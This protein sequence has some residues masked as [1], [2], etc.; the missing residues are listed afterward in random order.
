[1]RWK[2]SFLAR[3]EGARNSQ[4]DRATNLE[5]T[6]AVLVEL[7]R[8]ASCYGTYAVLSE[9]DDDLADQWLTWLRWVEEMFL[10]VE[11]ELDPALAE[12][13]SWLQQ[14]IYALENRDEIDREGIF[15]DQAVR[16]WARVQLEWLAEWARLTGQEEPPGGIE[17]AL[18]TAGMRLFSAVRDSLAHACAE[19]PAVRGK[20]AEA[21]EI[22]ED[23]IAARDHGVWE[24]AFG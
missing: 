15:D 13:P 18:S 21:A 23:L 3:V 12:T 14:V 10:R 20:R 9:C 4:V 22:L 6:T 8:A 5:A 11:T 17:D 24:A 19:D 2:P 16:D 7:L 1:M